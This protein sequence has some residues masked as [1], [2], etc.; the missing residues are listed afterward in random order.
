MTETVTLRCSDLSHEPKVAKLGEFRRDADTG[1]WSG[2]GYRRPGSRVFLVP[3][4]NAQTRDLVG[5]QPQTVGD[6][7][8]AG[9]DRG[10][11]RRFEA[12]CPLC[13]LR[14]VARADRVDE[15][16][17]TLVKAGLDSIDLRSLA[18]SLR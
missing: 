7:A 17:D 2:V 11:R 8:S 1:E 5:D 10:E 13:G 9:R 15:R 6:L 18:A 12:E 16:F 4:K 14:L 3:G